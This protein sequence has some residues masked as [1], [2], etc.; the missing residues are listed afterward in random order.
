MSRPFDPYHKWLGIA[1]ADQPPNHYRLLGIGLFEDDPDVVSNAVDQRMRH[2][3]V[4]QSGPHSDESQ[5]I[6]NEIATAKITLLNLDKKK[7][8]DH[9]LRSKEAAQATELNTPNRG[10]STSTKQKLVVAQPL[11]PQATPVESLIGAPQPTPV[12]S[13][14][15]EPQPVPDEPLVDAPQA[16]PVIPRAELASTTSRHSR[17]RSDQSPFQLSLQVKLVLVLAVAVVALVI[18]LAFRQRGAQD[19]AKSTKTE[20]TTQIVPDTPPDPGNNDEKTDPVDKKVE[21]EDNADRQPEPGEDSNEPSDTVAETSEPPTPPSEKSPQPDDAAVAEA[22][23]QLEAASPG[24]SPDELLRRAIDRTVYDAETYALLC[25][26]RDRANEAGDFRTAV[27]AINTLV[28]RFQIEAVDMF[29][30]ALTAG[31]TAASSTEDHQEIARIALQ[32]GGRAIELD[33]KDL[34]QDCATV[35]LS[36]ARKARDSDLIRRATLAIVELRQP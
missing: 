21:T 26:A 13:L 33:R 32:L 27:M 1:P 22:R 28:S 30:D 2:V 20:E 8:Y 14:I 36:A 35:A 15:N 5:Q 18:A 3:R 24:E 25:L 11:E 7:E 34:A 17:P 31:Q 19:V 23:L 12:E 6:L 9:L 29:A 10:P 16:D 4:Y